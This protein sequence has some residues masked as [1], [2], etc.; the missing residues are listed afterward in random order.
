MRD[1]PLH[2]T[3]AAGTTLLAEPLAV[4]A[5]WVGFELLAAQ[6]VRHGIVQLLAGP[7]PPIGKAAAQHTKQRRR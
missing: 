6:R 3:T 4:T 1:H 7:P 5:E 2:S